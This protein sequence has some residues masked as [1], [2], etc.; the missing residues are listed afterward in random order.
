MLQ[1]FHEANRDIL[2]NINGSLVH[3]DQAGV[4][5]FDSSVQNGD[6]VWEGLRVY[7]GK[8]FKLTEHLQRLRRSAE[9]LAYAEVPSDDAI[10]DAIRRTLAA[11][12]MRTDVHIRL[13]L[14]RGVKRTSGA[15]R[16]G[17]AQTA[18]L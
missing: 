12:D 8:I 15:D 18:G 9:A 1:T 11:N 14:T 4:S 16:P 2:V 7:D 3:R 17:R 6:A 10:I 13:T 5:P